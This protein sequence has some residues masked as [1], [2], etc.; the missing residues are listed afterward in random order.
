VSTALALAG[1]APWWAYLLVGLSGPAAYIYRLRGLYRL[2]GK[3]LDKAESDQ[4]A[5]VMTTVTG[6]S[7]QPSPETSPRGRAAHRARRGSPRST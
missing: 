5:A 6:R 1:D 7:A 4:V 2:A 3:A